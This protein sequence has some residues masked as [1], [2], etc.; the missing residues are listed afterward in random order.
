MSSPNT[1]VVSTLSSFN[2]SRGISE[3]SLALARFEV[4]LNDIRL[5][6]DFASRSNNV[7]TYSSL[8]FS[9][10]RQRAYILSMVVSTVFHLLS[11]NREAMRPKY[12]AAAAKS[13]SSLDAC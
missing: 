5:A 3:M 8:R 11:A 1:P 9:F 2:Q 13:P 7:R 12:M 4:V 10:L 6:A